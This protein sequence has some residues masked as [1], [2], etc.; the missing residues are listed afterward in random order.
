MKQD[1]SKQPEPPPKVDRIP[2]AHERRARLI[3]ELHAQAI[4]A[5]PQHLAKVVE[6][7]DV[8]RRRTQTWMIAA[9]ALAMTL[10]CL[11]TLFGL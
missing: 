2:S 5:L 7:K 4:E 8:R 10:A 6:A 3:G 9:A 1:G 11:F